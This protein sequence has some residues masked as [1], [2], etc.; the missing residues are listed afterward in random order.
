VI[1]ATFSGKGSADTGGSR[2]EGRSLSNPLFAGNPADAV[3]TS[4][5]QLAAS[6]R[7]GSLGKFMVA[8]AVAAQGLAVALSGTS[9]LTHLVKG[10][11][12]EARAA[13][14]SVLAVILVLSGLSFFGIRRVL[15][16][17]AREPFR[18][19]FYLAPFDLIGLREEHAQRMGWLQRD[20]T[21][22]ICS[23]ISRLSLLDEPSS[24]E[25]EEASERA[26]TSDAAIRNRTHLHVRGYCALR[27]GPDSTLPH[28]E[29]RAWVRFGLKGQP[30][31]LAP[32]VNFTLHTEESGLPQLALLDYERIVDRVYFSVAT[33]VYRHIHDD[34]ERKI[35]TLPGSHLKANAYFYEAEDYARSNTLDA[36]AEAEELY[37]KSIDLFAPSARALPAYS[38]RRFVEKCRRMGRRLWAFI[39]RRGARFFPRLGRRDV[40][41]ARAEIGRARTLLYRR[42]LGG[43][44]G[45]RMAPIF[46]APLLLKSA[47]RR[48]DD[49]VP[50]G[51]P[52][53]DA[54]LFEAL[55]LLALSRHLLGAPEDAKPLIAEARRLN[56]EHAHE[57]AVLAFVSAQL[58]TEP[59][60]RLQLLRAA[61]ELNPKYQ[62][63]RYSLALELEMVWRQHGQLEPTVAQQVIDE[64]RELIGLN[65]SIVAAWANLGYVY[66]LLGSPEDLSR[67]REALERALEYKEIKR[68]KFV[69]E[70]DL[71]LA[72]VAVEDGRYVDA[73]KHFDEAVAATLA[74]EPHDVDTGIPTYWHQY[75]SKDILARFK[76]YRDSLVCALDGPG[77]MPELQ[78][79]PSGHPTHT[80]P[81][82]YVR[83]A[84]I[85][86]VVN[87]YADT[88]V[89][90]G[91]RF[92]DDDAID[93]AI[94]EYTR[95]ASE[96]GR[97]ILPRYALARLSSRRDEECAR[98]NLHE[99]EE[100]DPHWPEALLFASE[101]DAESGNIDASRR[102][103]QRLLKRPWAGDGKIGLLIKTR[104][105]LPFVGVPDGGGE[106]AG[107]ADY[108]LAARG[109]RPT[110]SP[111]QV[112][113]LVTW[114]RLF[115]MENTV[116]ASVAAAGICQYVEQWYYPNY[117]KVQAVARMAAAQVLAHEGTSNGRLSPATRALRD[118]FVKRLIDRCERLAAGCA[119]D[120]DDSQA[121]VLRELAQVVKDWKGGRRANPPG[122]VEAA[123]AARGVYTLLIAT[124]LITWIELDRQHQQPRRQLCELLANEDVGMLA[125]PGSRLERLLRESAPNEARQGVT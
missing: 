38:L 73:Y 61:V 107:L 92:A 70:L 41:L 95:A 19:T 83:R 65:P 97:F 125:P 8:G 34:V 52:D 12:T 6:A 60:L 118:D 27:E 110:L 72:R 86:Y 99:I 44:S 57:D 108:L 62:V 104:S 30:E 2:M 119:E 51:V 116:S 98:K 123:A 9:T 115:A 68:A 45:A 58:E 39:L 59:V 21:E 42:Q 18:Y 71:G 100:L 25:G 85:A 66:W 64:Y 79:P 11:L 14:P 24:S 37:R 96:N 124:S 15:S 4:E 26:F 80:P 84:V 93:E 122:R 76:E 53:R 13:W 106:A 77:S 50:K 112:E 28:V 82:E 111:A 36:Y 94:A 121:E 67:A 1:Y 113:A 88:L 103:I 63:A 89:A 47:R 16:R 81:T 109:A 10:N 69:S 74:R 105:R 101:F 48:L 20:L 43:L 29:V 35:A 114:A 31:T 54:A 33:A 3:A 117:T 120:E 17:D 5:R 40:L 91:L 22:R 7:F 87:D 78:S 46:D 75:I 49:D 32:V 90:Y 55:V 102:S 23:E 56:A